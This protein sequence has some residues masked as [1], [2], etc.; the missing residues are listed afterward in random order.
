MATLYVWSGAGGANDGTSWTDAWT[1]IQSA[2]TNWTTADVVYIA[3]DHS[4][5]QATEELFGADAMDDRTPFIIY[6]VDR[7]DDSYLPATAAQI[8]VTGA[9]IDID[10]NDSIHAH[11][12]FFQLEDGNFDLNTTSQSWRF[13]DCNFKWTGTTAD[14]GITLGG[15]GVF[16]GCTFDNTSGSGGYQIAGGNSGG[17]FYGCTFQGR[18][19][20]A[21]FFDM[22]Q[23]RGLVSLFVGC[24]FSGL[25]NVTNLNSASSRA[26]VIS[27]KIASGDGFQNGAAGQQYLTTA[28]STAVDGAG[29][30]KNYIAEHYFMAGTVTQDTAINRDSGWTDEDG[31]TQLSHKMAPTSNLKGA[32]TP[33]YGPDLRAYIDS[34]G[35][36]TFT[37]Y[38]V[39]DF[40]TAPN[41]DEAW[42]EVFY[43]GTANSVLWSLGGGRSVFS[44]TAWTVGTEAWTG[45][46][47]KTKME[48]SATVTVNKAGT[49]AV[50]VHLG[51][52]EA[53]KALWYCPLVEVA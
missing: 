42:L 19:R 6:S 5:T 32:H 1:D 49:Y 38:A 22:G 16:I 18:S 13:E 11:G 27:C 28:Y 41:Q 9:A 35:S 4:Q 44:T 37:V 10:F 47:G 36:K 48:L 2:W 21:Q 29:T 45:A 26:A 31:D 15:G 52:Y 39:H 23:S 30:A 24:D 3:S 33:I 43:L 34:T 12:V 7:T 14:R 20:S 50:R 25:T 40:T 51:K 8:A 53:S 17:D 46:S